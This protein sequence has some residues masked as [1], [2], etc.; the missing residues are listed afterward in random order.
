[1]NEKFKQFL[2]KEI[3]LKK[4]QSTLL[5][6]S[7]GAD[8]VVMAELFHQAQQPFAIA[9]V[10]FQLRGT[11][12][13]GDEAFVRDLAKRFKVPC[14]VKSFDTKELAKAQNSSTQMLARA[15]R[16]TWFEEIRQEKGF[17]FIATAHHINDSIETVLFNLAKGTGIAGLHGILPRKNYLIRPLLFASRQ[18]IRTFIA[19]HQLVFRE[20]SS[21][22]ED[23]YRRNFI[24]Q[25]I[26]PKMKDLNPSL[27]HTFQENIKRFRD[28]ETVF[29]WAIEQFKAKAFLQKE[30]L[31]YIDIEKTSHTPAPTTLLFEWLRPYGFNSDQV[32]QIWA[33]ASAQ[34]GSRFHSP[35]HELLRDRTHWI[36]RPKGKTTSKTAIYI[37]ENQTLT[38]YPTG[39]LAL[40]FFPTATLKISPNPH[41]AY[42]DLEKI[43]FPLVLRPW[44][45]GDVFQPFGMN[46]KHKKL[47]D[48][49]ID[50]RLSLHEK[51]SS[52][53]LES[54][55]QICWVIGKRIDERFRIGKRTKQALQIQWIGN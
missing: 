34:S 8:S 53:V 22:K 15:L 14:F 13:D 30:D 26:I 38:Q 21:N 50:L 47:S 20:D 40:S 10:N 37:Q 24:R 45:Q 31:I 5:A 29:Q 46:G 2:R 17:D 25:H 44:Q 3:G 51:E 33:T 42:L 18:D 12:S 28:T 19:T 35:S 54:N 49:F 39:Q 4:Q 23:K 11:E 36:I 41:F 16:Y 52:W 7:G 55:G 1:M 43:K 48:F 32:Q 27:E 6:V 9:H